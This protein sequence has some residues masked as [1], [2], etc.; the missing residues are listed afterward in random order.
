MSDSA[1]L[2]TYFQRTRYGLVISTHPNS[3]F[4]NHLILARPDLG[5]RYALKNNQLT[6]HNQ[7]SHTERH[8]LK[9]TKALRATL[10]DAFRLQLLE[11]LDLDTALQ[12]LV[13]PVD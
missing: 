6:I 10:E 2:D 5:Y 4:T 7:D 13:E 1:D 3:I 9:S 8:C 12:R 11:H